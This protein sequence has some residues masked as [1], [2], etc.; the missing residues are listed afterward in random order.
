MSEDCYTPKYDPEEHY[1]PD[2]EEGWECLLW[3]C[4]E[5]AEEM[6]KGGKEKHESN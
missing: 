3:N 1:R 2:W 5:H 4:S 6:L